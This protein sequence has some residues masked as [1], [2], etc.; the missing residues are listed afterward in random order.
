M[1]HLEIKVSV[2]VPVYN[3]ELYLEKC[4]LSLV[5]QTLQDVEIIVVNDGSKDHSQQIIEKF[6]QEY[7][8]K[9]FGFTK[10]N[11]GLS[12]ARNFGIDRARG[13]YIGFVDSDDYVSETMFEDM[14]NIAEKHQAEITICNLQK[15]DERGNVTQ[16]L[17]QLPG[18]PE[19][20]ILENNMSVF[21]DI[22][23]FACNKLFRRELFNNR[24]F[25]KRIHFEDIE[26]IPQLFLASDI[27]GFTPAY[28]YQYLERSASISKTHTLKGL[29]ILKAVETV[30]VKFDQSIYRDHKAALKNFQILEG[31]YTFLAY[32]AFVKNQAD[33]FR[34]SQ[35]L[36][37]FL[38]INNI[39]T[40][41]ILQ[42][43]RFGRNY[44]LSL[45]I[46]KKIYYV[47][48]IFRLRRVVR[49]LTIK[50]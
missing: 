5:H 35:E 46:G 36:D 8:E 10:E 24:R 34:M 11:G 41:D 47:L 15:V 48:S 1:Q 13:K 31:V 6:Q 32:L 26:L 22:S 9:I 30:T 33:Y 18:F 49:M 14:M 27:I 17:T 29:D 20:I 28:H 3:V 45:P 25:R 43:K 2:I 37:L 39:K 7:P 21:S 12:D 44:L 4:L 23:Y 42:Y 50:K 38:G 40:K 19:K 16:K